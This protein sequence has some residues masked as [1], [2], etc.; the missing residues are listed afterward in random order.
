MNVNI[1]GTELVVEF[2]CADC[3]RTYKTLDHFNR[4][5]NLRLGPQNGC[6][7]W[8]RGKSKGVEK[9]VKT[10]FSDITKKWILVKR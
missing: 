1:D 6:R 9:I 10:K 5:Y 7:P 4:Y 3:Y 8:V 2:Y